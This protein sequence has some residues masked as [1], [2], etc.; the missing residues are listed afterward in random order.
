MLVQ[1]YCLKHMPQGDVGLINC[2]SPAFTV[3]L[4]FFIL[5]ERITIMDI[6]NILIVF[7]GVVLIIK[8]PFIFGYS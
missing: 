3:L 2:S 1:M 7:M 8:P 4:A 5:H 6:F